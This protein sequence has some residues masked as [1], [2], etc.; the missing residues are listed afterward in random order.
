METGT[1][2]DG[3]LFMHS[4]EIGRGIRYFDVVMCCLYAD[5]GSSYRH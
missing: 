1:L 2:R 3:L 5:D 4:D